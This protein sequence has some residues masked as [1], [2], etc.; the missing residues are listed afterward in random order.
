M[1]HMILLHQIL[2][3]SISRVVFLH[4][5][6]NKVTNPVENITSLVEIN[7]QLIELMVHFAVEHYSISVVE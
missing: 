3:K 5:P 2:R 1:S 6:A 7:R 4:I